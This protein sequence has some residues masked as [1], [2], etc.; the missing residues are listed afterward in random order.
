MPFMEA[1]RLLR[2][3]SGG[4]A[5]IEWES[6]GSCACGP[7]ACC[8]NCFEALCLCAWLCRCVV[9]EEGDSVV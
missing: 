8:Q 2:D 7:R 3:R 5:G 6:G 9:C 1:V 4:A